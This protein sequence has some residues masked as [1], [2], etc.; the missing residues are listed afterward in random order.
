MSKTLV[1]VE[2]PVKA[3]KIQGFLGSDYKVMASMGHI[4]D[5]G[6]NGIANTGIDIKNNFKPKY[7]LLDDKVAI[8]SAILEEAQKSDLILVASDGDRE[9]EAIAWHLAS[10][11]SGLKAPIK[12]M[13]F[14][15]IKKKTILA[16]IA[17]VR[18][19]NL[20]LFHSQETRRMLDRI[21]GFMGSTY[22][23]N[24]MNQKLSAGRVQSVVTKMIV[25]R[26][27]EINIFNPEDFWTI[28]AKM[29]AQ[30]GDFEVK[31]HGRPVTQKEADAVVSGSNTHYTITQVERKPEFVHPYAPLVTSTLQRLMSKKFGMSADKTMKAAQS[32]YELG[33]CTYIR[34][35]SVR[36]SDEAMQ[37][38]RDFIKSNYKLPKSPNEFKNKN[39]AQDAHECIRPSDLSLKP[40]NGFIL[41]DPDQQKVYEMIWKYFIASQMM[42]A[43]YDTLKIKCVSTDGKFIYK[44]S[45]RALIDKGFL[46]VLGVED[47]SSIDIPNL[48]VGEKVAIKDIKSIKKQTQPPPRFSEDKLIK[49][50]EN[51]N[52]GRPATYADLLSKISVRNYVEKK[53]SVFYPTK[54]G[55]KVTSNLNNYFK[56]MD[57]NYTA[58]LEAKL[59]KIEL[60]EENK[61]KVL[62]DFFIEFK[63]QL[64]A[65]YINSGT[66]LC[67]KCGSAMVTMTNR[68]TQEQFVSCSNYKICR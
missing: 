32:L 63:S 43:K 40:D 64:D 36:C 17:N 6:K 60:G 11:L 42:P 3:E 53:G 58:D 12:R 16:S 62:N 2:S 39:S 21:V 22:L 28:T 20:N 9:G 59:D 4:T 27:Q 57:Y 14:N 68:S 19:I 7:V 38:V 55:I 23:M 50:L 52:I 67:D 65:A 56:F 25:D 5:L 48:S 37:E 61:L 18:D 54:L 10:R 45:G 13:V 33:Y 24:T 8:F 31:Y 66:K 34:T 29:H 26:E 51:N 1:I 30:A 49:E 46:E 47:N 35:D 41:T 44:A 15:E